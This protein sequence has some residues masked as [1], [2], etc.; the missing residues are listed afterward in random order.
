MTCL[1]GSGLNAQTDTSPMITISSVLP[2]DILPGMP[3]SNATLQ[4]AAEFAWQEF[5]ALNWPAKDGVRDTP[6]T[7]KL[8]GASDFTGPLVWHT[9]RHKVETYPGLGQG[10]PPGFVDDHTQDYGYDA[11]PPVYNYKDGEIQPCTGQ[12]AVTDPA[13]INLDE[14]SQIGLNH[15]LQGWLPRVPRRTAIRS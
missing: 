13:W 6:D 7:S 4:Q 5:I 11:R 8:F 2:T 3:S 14:I 9:Y 12:E 10:N 1:A 15:I